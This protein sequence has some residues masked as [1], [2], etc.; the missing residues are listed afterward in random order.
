MTI[1]YSPPGSADKN[2]TNSL[3][4][5][6]NK[7]KSVF[8]TVSAIHIKS[9]TAELRWMWEDRN[10]KENNRIKVCLKHQVPI[11]PSALFS[12]TL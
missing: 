9:V 2:T 6:F 11:D 3:L 10:L 1:P 5:V 8:M 7:F 12:N 4:K